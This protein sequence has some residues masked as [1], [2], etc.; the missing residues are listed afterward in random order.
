[1]HITAA[2]QETKVN[3]QDAELL[4]AALYADKIYQLGYSVIPAEDSNHY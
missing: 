4:L 2:K 1:M 3:L